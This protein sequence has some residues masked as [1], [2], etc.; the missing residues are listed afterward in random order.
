MI[1]FI[2]AAKYVEPC[3]DCRVESIVVENED[4]KKDKLAFQFAVMKAFDNMD[5][6]D[7]VVSVEMVK[8]EEG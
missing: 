7:K 6:G 2:F 4:I 3:G 1:K 5:I 8:R